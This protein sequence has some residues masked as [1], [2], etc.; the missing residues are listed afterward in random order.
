VPITSIA[1][2][3]PTHDAGVFEVNS[4]SD[5]ERFLPFEGASAISTWRLDLNTTSRTF[6][7]AT[8]EGDC[9]YGIYVA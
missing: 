9:A 6:D 7:Y 4:G 8:I 5:A 3:S 2:S 1:T